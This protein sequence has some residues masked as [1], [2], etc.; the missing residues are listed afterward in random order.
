MIK[1]RRIRLANHVA[2]M[3][4]KEW[5]FQN[6]TGKPTG[7]GPLGRPRHKWEDNIRMDLKEIFINTG[8]L[9][10]LTQDRDYFRVLVNAVLKLRVP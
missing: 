2:R 1:S 10:L 3:E 9:V 8:N 7:K 5:C 6:L 4:K